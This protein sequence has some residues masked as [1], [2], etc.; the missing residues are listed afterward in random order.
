MIMLLLHYSGND[1]CRFLFFLYLYYSI[2]SEEKTV[3]FYFFLLFL[4]RSGNSVPGYSLCNFLCDPSD[5]RNDN[6]VSCLLVQAG[7]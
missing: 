3:F 4:K 1:V 6:G 2:F 5:H 7:V